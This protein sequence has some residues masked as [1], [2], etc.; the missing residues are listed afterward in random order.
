MNDIA[1]GLKIK[2]T[3]YTG[4]SNPFKYHEAFHAVFRTLLTNEQQ[5]RLYAGAKKDVKKKYGAKYAEELEKFKN[6]ADKYRAMGAKALE[7]EFLEEY[8]ADE[9]EK[10]KKDP[11]ST[12]AAT[13]IKNFFNKLIEWLKALFGTYSPNELQNLFREIDSG[14]FKSASPINNRF[15]DSLATGITVNANKIIPVDFVES[16]SGQFGYRV[17][18]NATAKSI[19]NGITA[20]VVQLELDNKKANFNVEQAVDDSFSKF[21]ALYSTRREG[22]NNLNLTND[23]KR[24]LR[25]IEKA[26]AEYGDSI[27]ENV[28]E[29]L[30][31]YEIKSTNIEEA[32]EED[33][34]DVGDRVRL[35]DQYDKDVT[36]IGGF[37]SLSTFL[38]KYIG[39]TSLY[40]K[41]QFGNDYLID[42]ELDANGK[43]VPGTGEKLMV[44]VDFATAYNG[45]L[46]AVKNVSD[47]IKILQRM[48]L[49]GISNPQTK[50][51]VDKLFDDLGI[52][53]EGQLE[54]GELPQYTAEVIEKFKAGE[55]IPA[56]ELTQG[57]R[58][59]LLFQAVLKG[60]E[61]ARVDYLFVHRTEGGRV[62]T[63]SAAKRDDAHTQI[64]RW[65]QAYLVL[66]KRLNT[67]EGVKNIVVTQLNKLI[68]KLQYTPADKEE[69]PEK[70]LKEI[71][72]QYLQSLAAKTS[73]VLFNNVGIYL[74]PKFIE[75]SIVK[76]VVDLKPYQKA[77]LN[78][79]SDEKAL[80]QNDIK[81]I[82]KI[83]EDN[84]PLFATTDEGAK[85]RLNRIAL[86]NAA[87]DENVG[88]SVF[89]NPNGDLVYAH[90][91]PTF[92]LKKI[93]ELN[94]V[95][96]E[97][98][99]IEQL[100]TDRYLANNLLVND[101]AFKKMSAD[102][103]LRVLRI[104]GSKK[105]NIDVNEDGMMSE[106]SGKTPTS[107]KTYG[108]ST[109]RDFI[110]N[111]INAYTYGVDSLKGDVRSVVWENEDGTINREAI[112]PV[113]MRVLEA[114]NTGDMLPLPVKKAVE[115]VKGE[116]VISDI[117]LNAILNNIKAEFE[118][119]QKES[120]PETATQELIVGFNA[121]A[122]RN[123]ETGTDDIVPIDVASSNVDKARAFN[124]NK[125][126]VLLNPLGKKKESRQGV[127]TLQTS[128]AKFDRVKEGVQKSLV[129]DQKVAA[130]IIGFTTTG[131]TRRAVVKTKESEEGVSAVI[132]SK[133]LVRVTPEN[134]DAIFTAL[135]GSISTIK[136]DQYKYEVKVGVEKFY[137][138]SKNEKLFLQ[139]K[140]PMYMYDLIQ[141]GDI[142]SDVEV[143]FK[144]TGYEDT[145]LDAAR[146]PENKDLTFEESLEKANISKDDL[147]SFIRFRL[148]QEFDQFNILLD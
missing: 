44:T 101:P 37:S 83:I 9:F 45:F 62:V 127:V 89:K 34:A 14:K 39:T 35:T 95:G 71:S 13:P 76:N 80:D 78:A 119:I 8:M 53:W 22:Y 1:G 47:P 138:E 131:V 10:F 29:Q 20:R 27:K 68:S 51:V 111:L 73:E 67:D 25:D 56:E 59:P 96:G 41:D 79:N 92:H 64:D 85:N 81:A 5:D 60:F 90:Q 146:S 54:N 117:T 107:G 106:T 3:I 129:Y 128:D 132:Q 32:N 122:T 148:N 75:Y 121:E 144:T 145:L 137:V 114:S 104:S 69:L 48:Y 43:V 102:G 40:E 57:I 21:R 141:A 24:S 139:G 82:K 142:E 17:L 105:G 91:L 49:F 113:L 130:E 110:L 143:D 16:E 52:K 36:S 123:E 100:K 103:T 140:K 112:A 19:V 108:D 58:K 87:F 31:F 133:G 124:F 63:Y 93:Q 77:L 97:G 120:N 74:H 6:S 147:L 7:R 94:D 109:P 65:G 46:K 84:D 55:P 116:T 70:T 33:D 125:T 66:S 86:G 42:P 115:K 50:A 26:F 30:K 118:R 72:D 126:G 28:Y 88:A 12:K 98:S 2:G 136:D 11:R 38:R 99:T 135:E 134:R 23:Q 4:A 61:N 18:D 15:T